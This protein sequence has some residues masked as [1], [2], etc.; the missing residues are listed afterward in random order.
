VISARRT[1]GGGALATS[2]ALRSTSS[3]ALLTRTGGVESGAGTG[4]TR[5][6]WGMGSQR[7]VTRSLAMALLGMSTWFMEKVVSLV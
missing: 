2:W 6:I 4:T 7:L 1:R 5:L 3:R